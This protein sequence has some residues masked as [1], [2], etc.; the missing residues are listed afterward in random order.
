MSPDDAYLHLSFAR[1]V[2]DGHRAIAGEHCQFLPL[3]GRV[4]HRFRHG[5][6]GQ[7]LF[8]PGQ[9]L[10]L[11]FRQAGT[12]CACRNASLSATDPSVACFATASSWPSFRV[13]S[14]RNFAMP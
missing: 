12:D 2:V 8:F 3:A 7:Q 5:M 4:V 1:V 11:Q 13:A 10:P 14:S 6:L 9:Q